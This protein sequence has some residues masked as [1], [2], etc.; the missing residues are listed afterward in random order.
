MSSNRTPKK[1]LMEVEKAYDTR[2]GGK[3]KVVSSELF[4]DILESELVNPD[5]RSAI[6]TVALLARNANNDTENVNAHRT[7]AVLVARL[8]KKDN[9]FLSFLKGRIRDDYPVAGAI[10]FAQRR[11]LQLI[12][13]VEEEKWPTIK[14]LLGTM[15]LTSIFED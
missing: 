6:L 13:V 14:I 8:V 9:E 3:G 4:A 15:Q 1:L 5:L 2:I 7:F 10:C 11:R 12:D